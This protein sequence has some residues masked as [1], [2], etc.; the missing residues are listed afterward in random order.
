MGIARTRAEMNRRDGWCF[1]SKAGGCRSSCCG[2]PIWPYNQRPG[3]SERPASLRHHVDR[4]GPAPTLGKL[5]VPKAHRMQLGAWLS[6]KHHALVS[7]SRLAPQRDGEAMCWVSGAAER[8]GFTTMHSTIEEVRM[9]SCAC[10]LWETK[11]LA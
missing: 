10:F 11:R 8:R 3:A 2:L 5:S 7:L 9:Y 1:C 4:M 6:Y